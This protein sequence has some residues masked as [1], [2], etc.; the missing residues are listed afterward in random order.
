MPAASRLLTNLTPR[1]RLVLAGCAL[2]LIVVV[3]LGMQMAGRPSFTL[4][5]SGLDPAETGKVTAALDE[6]GIAYELRNNGTALAVEKTQTAQARIALASAGLEGGGGSQP[7]FE[8]FD[9]QKLGSSDFQQ[10]VTYQ[11]ALEGQVATT[12]GQVQGVDGAQVRLVLAEDELFSE[13]ATPATAAVLLSGSTSGLK[14]GAVRGI[15]QLVASS[16]KGLKTDNVS[17]TDGNGELLWPRGEGGA[18][19]GA[20]ASKQTVQARYETQVEAGVAALLTRTLGPGKAEVQVSADVNADETTKDELKYGESTPTKET[21]ETEKLR[22]GSGSGGSG[23][24]TSANVPSYAQSAAGGA[25][26][27]Y[28]RKSTTRS[29]GVDKT[30]TR[31]KVAPGGV[32]R[33]DVALVVDK[34]V[35]KAD[36]PAIRAAVSS[37]A[38]VVPARGD[39]IALSQIAFAKP[40]KA[41]APAAG[42]AG[43]MLGYAKIAGAGIGILLFLFFSTRQLRRREGETLMREPNWLR[44]IEAPTTLAHLERPRESALPERVGDPAQMQ[45]EE[46]AE[47]E[48]ER[49]AQQ[50]RTWMRDA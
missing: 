8:L 5:S 17:I 29:F 2:A 11:R 37:A 16:V 31:T 19:A 30:V 32:N 36:L 49:V 26:S 6:E 34:S 1:G 44:E 20:G 23:S 42:P 27:N 33:M 40:E 21:T 46:L 43:G 4:M 22:G 28:D 50:I 7:G 48:P 47:R 24:G 13:S 14:T 12:I 25:A 18:G 10:K 35:P 15:A 41:G 9:K 39:T 38:G 3:V 45:V